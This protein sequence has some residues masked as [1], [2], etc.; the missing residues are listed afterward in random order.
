MKSTCVLVWALVCAL[1]TPACRAQAA[2]SNAALESLSALIG[3]QH[4]AG[5]AGP[6]LSLEEVLRMALAENP[7]IH[8]SVRRVAAAE[9]HV[10][11]ASTLDDPQFMYR[12]W[13]VPLSKPW[14]YNQAQNMLMIGQALPGPGKRIL[15][16]AVAKSDVSEAKAELAA[17]RLRI[18]V[19]ARKAFYDLLR[20]EDEIR[21]HDQH[22]G[23]AHQAIEAA[24]IKYTVGK[25][26]QVEILKAQL[27]L[28][29]LAEHMIRFERDAD[30]ARA[31][32]N[33]LLGREPDAPIQAHGEYGLDHALPS[34]DALERVAMQSRPD[35]IEAEAAAEKTRR[36][37][38]VAKKTYVPDFNVAAGYMLM[39]AGSSARNNYMV[40][41]SVSLPWL[42]R[43]KHEAELAE[44]AAGITEKDAELDAMRN[45]ARGQIQEALAEAKAAQRLA[46]VY[47]D[48]LRQQSEETL[49]SAVIAYEND[50]TS[51]LDLLDS[52]MTVVDVDL[53][54]I[55]ALGEFNMRIAE[56]EMAAGAPVEQ[57]QPGVAKEMQ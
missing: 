55:D 30:V 28:T 54:W 39:P 21:I 4:E 53:A 37:Q 19:D 9:A 44:A 3:G 41:G 17:T 8:V 2:D 25:I 1:S 11:A 23:I 33:A 47:Q 18:Q 50:Q 20:A 48:S 45:A 32:L 36:E 14:D 42:N 49:H 43:R 13:Q 12:G 35:L 5:V 22:V 6:A 15:H 38:A 52:Q 56:L 46:R 57:S 31:R 24:R 10:P 16:A 27:A 26:P 7:E 40:E 34:L 51:F 29:R